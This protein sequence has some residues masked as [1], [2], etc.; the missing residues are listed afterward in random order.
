MSREDI[1]K[2]A[3]NSVLNGKLSVEDY[4]EILQEHFDLLD[5][6]NEDLTQRN[7]ILNEKYNHLLNTM[8]KSLTEHKEFNS[9]K[10]QLN[11]H[12]RS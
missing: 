11:R 10:D 3:L 9:V 6:R 7:K 8:D 12:R 2:K 4:W 5:K 1:H